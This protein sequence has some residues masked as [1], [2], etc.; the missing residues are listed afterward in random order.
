MK[1][2]TQSQNKR[3]I[4]VV[5]ADDHPVFLEGVVSLL[6]EME[7]VKVVDTALNG[8]QVIQLLND[9]DVDVVITDIN[10]PGMD[11]I[12]LCQ[13][14]KKSYAHIKVLVLTI[15]RVPLFFKINLKSLDI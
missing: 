7:E 6:G 2:S 5:V 8:S 13:K 4:K 12:A 15:T 10:M 14:I 11:G 1:Q 9:N 3:K